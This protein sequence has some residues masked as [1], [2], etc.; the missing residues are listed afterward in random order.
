MDKHANVVSPC[1]KGGAGPVVVDLMSPN[2]RR[3]ILDKTLREGAA[4]ETKSAELIARVTKG[5]KNKFAKARLGSKAAKHAERMEA[6]GDD[7]DQEAATMYR[8]LSAR[9][10]TLAWT[11][12]RSP[13]PPKNSAATLRTQPSLVWKG[14][15]GR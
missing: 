12:P 11:V 10:L 7:L 9:L 14:S 8:A 2:M 15:R 6:G 4:W 3:S 13:L 1:S 5:P